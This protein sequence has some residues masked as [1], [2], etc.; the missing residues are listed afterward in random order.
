MKKILT[1]ALMF[2]AI[3]ATAQDQSASIKYSG[4]ATLFTNYLQ[5]GVRLSDGP[6]ASAAIGLSKSTQW[7][8]VK[9][10]LAALSIDNSNTTSNGLFG[11]SL[12]LQRSIDDGVDLQ[13]IATYNF[14]DDGGLTDDITI[15]T[16]ARAQ[17]TNSFALNGSFTRGRET[18]DTG[19]ANILRAAFDIGGLVLTKSVLTVAG[20]T[21]NFPNGTSQALVGANQIQGLRFDYGIPLMS[22]VKLVTFADSNT[23]NGNTSGASVTYTR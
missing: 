22:R 7:G 15:T 18:Y 8:T 4:S 5:D 6:G 16:S 9:A 14:S 11:V 1:T 2:T 13:T 23:Q 19:R 10:G 3:C 17:I 12:G 20:Y 21:A